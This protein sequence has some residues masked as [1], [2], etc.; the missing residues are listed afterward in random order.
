MFNVPN[1]KLKNKII[2]YLLK[3]KIS[4]FYPIQAL[5]PPIS[6]K[7]K[8]W[9]EIMERHNSNRPYYYHNGGIWP[10]IGGF[11]VI[12]LFKLGKKKL[13]FAELEKLAFANK[14]NNWEFNEWFSGKTGKPM[15][16]PGQSWNAGTFLLACH[17]LKNDFLI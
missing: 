2:N 12:M 3:Q 4:K 17:Y 14:R 9:D 16:M 7:D 8:G 10:Y 11:W 15:G 1:Q 13:A 5:V 6:K